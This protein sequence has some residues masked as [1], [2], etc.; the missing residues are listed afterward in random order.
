MNLDATKH[1]LAQTL[2]ALNVATHL[3]AAL[4]A[5]FP[6]TA[7]GYHVGSPAQP[8]QA[9]FHVNWRDGAGCANVREVAERYQHP[10]LTVKLLRLGGECCEAATVPTEPDVWFNCV[11]CGTY[12]LGKR[13]ARQ[14]RCDECAKPAGGSNGCPKAAV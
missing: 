13:I 1:N 14:G 10:A 9:V 8:G 12:V 11:D 5:H 7:F 6:E 2:A 3:R 4:T